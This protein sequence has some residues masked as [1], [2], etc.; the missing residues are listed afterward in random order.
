[1]KESKP[2]HQRMNE[3]DSKNKKL[4]EDLKNKR[5]EK[6]QYASTKNIS[7]IQDPVNKNEEYTTEAYIRNKGKSRQKIIENFHVDNIV[8]RTQV[9]LEEKVKKLECEKKFMND[10]EER[11]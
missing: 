2:F 3:Y 8:N 6:T 1:M 7:I 9:F 10:Q 4:G 11:R 5:Y